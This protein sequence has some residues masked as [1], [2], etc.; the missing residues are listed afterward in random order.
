MGRHNSYKSPSTKKRNIGRL[1]AHLH[2]RIKV[3]RFESEKMLYKSQDTS[4]VSEHHP[5]NFFTSTPLRLQIACEECRNECAANHHLEIH[6][7]MFHGHWTGSTVH[8]CF[9]TSR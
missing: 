3:I 9:G 8:L 4:D 5:T 2:K 1:L 7:K 6:K